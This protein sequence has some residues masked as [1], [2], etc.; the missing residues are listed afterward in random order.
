[1]V[2]LRPDLDRSVTSST[3]QAAVGRTSH[4]SS[5]RPRAMVALIAGVGSGRQRAARG[6]TRPALIVASWLG[7]TG[8]WL[9]IGQHVR[10]D[11]IAPPLLGV[12]S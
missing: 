11:G 1:M 10:G 9:P 7:S 3:R 12:L 2:G 8:C 6:D 5:S 4:D